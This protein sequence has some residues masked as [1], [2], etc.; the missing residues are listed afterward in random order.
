MTKENREAKPCGKK[1]HTVRKSTK[2]KGRPRIKNRLKNKERPNY[3]RELRGKKKAL[4]EK[5]LAVR[6]ST[7]A[8]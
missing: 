4:W 6:K 3:K 2:L 8:T 1:A 5:A 7:E